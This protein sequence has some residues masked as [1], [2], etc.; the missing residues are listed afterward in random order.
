MK[1]TLALT[2]SY[3]EVEKLYRLM[4]FNIFAHNRDDYTKNFAFL[5]QPETGWHLAPAYHLTYSDST[6]G[7]H[8]TTINGNSLNSLIKVLYGVAETIGLSK[9]TYKMHYGAGARYGRDRTRQYCE[10]V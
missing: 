4:C 2:Q 1:H 9:K 5:Y 8:A 6:G 10:S 7:E 3:K